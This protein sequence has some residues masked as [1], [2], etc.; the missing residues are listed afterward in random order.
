AELVG[1]STGCTKGLGGSMHLLDT[2]TNFMGGY[3]IVGG[4]IP[5]AN[6]VGWAIKHRK[7]DQ[8]CLCF[9]GDGAANQG[10]FFEALCLAQL[11]KLPVV[12]ICENNFYAM[13][14]SLTR[15]SAVTDMSLRALGVG[16][17]RDRFEGFDVEEVRERIGR[18]VRFAREGNGPVL[19][20]IMTY[21]F[22]GHS[23]SDPAKYRPEGELDSRKK[24][25][26]PLKITEG[27]LSVAYGLDSARLTELKESVEAEAQD[28]WEFAESS[29]EPAPANLYDYV[30]TD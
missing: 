30:Y 2:E 7:G 20:E 17:A 16:M 3:G 5:L 15:Q 13:G 14:T 11:Y 12:F 4:Q 28:A 27:R 22:R 23:M 18:A 25:S 19:L 6:G 21:R 26:D 10:A 1:K 29:P 24:E 9:F 8:V